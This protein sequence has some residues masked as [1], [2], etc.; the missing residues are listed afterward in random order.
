MFFW[1]CH[2]DLVFPFRALKGIEFTTRNWF[3]CFP[4]GLIKHMDVR[5][6]GFVWVAFWLKLLAFSIFFFFG[7]G[8]VGQQGSE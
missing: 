5:M 6:L 3:S 2:Y 8:G 1:F 7:G 4:E